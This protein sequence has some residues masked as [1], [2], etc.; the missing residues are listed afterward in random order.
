MSNE[1]HWNVKHANSQGNLEQSLG[2]PPGNVDKQHEKQYEPCG[3]ET[4]R[5][6]SMKNEQCGLYRARD[7]SVKSIWTMQAICEQERGHEKSMDHTGH[8]EL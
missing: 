2:R 1:I 8:K 6:T 4:N 3:P 7:I 5:Y